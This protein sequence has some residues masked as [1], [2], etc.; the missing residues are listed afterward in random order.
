MISKVGVVVANLTSQTPIPDQISDIGLPQ[1][2]DYLLRNGSLYV[3]TAQK[4]TSRILNLL[5][6]T[7]SQIGENWRNKQKAAFIANQLGVFH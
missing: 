5:T 4:D 2:I 3:E 7:S 1:G 6:D